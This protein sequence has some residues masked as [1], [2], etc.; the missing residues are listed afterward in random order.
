MTLLYPPR[1]NPV[2][3]LDIGGTKIECAL[4][5]SD[6]TLSRRQ[7]IS[8]K[9]CSS[10]LFGAISELLKSVR[11]D[12]AVEALGVGCGGPM[13]NQGEFVSPL[14]I[15]VWREFS[16]LDSLRKS[17]GLDAFID[18]DAKALAL[19]E[20]RFGGAKGMSNYLSMVV[21]TGVGGGIVLDGR[22]LDG[23]E[24]NAGHIGHVIVLP[25]GRDC[26]CGARGCLEAE[27]SG[28]AIEQMTGAPA[29]AASLEVKQ[30]TGFLVGRAV[31][32]VAAL[33]D[34]ERCFI[35]GSVALGFGKP[36]FDAANDSVR[37]H[38]HISHASTLLIEPSLLTSD[39]PLLGAACV[40]WRALDE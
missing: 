40:A 32:S 3:A 21:S 22:L 28:A 10:N 8:T 12:T 14:N 11:R 23:S 15:P 16:L 27:T 30:R 5:E 33:L 6:G 1:E 13:R 36:F 37:Q 31:S 19:G 17:T 18:N 25:D 35:A 2:L 7:R 34:V 4:V 38:A 9:E 20:G 26:A 29:I 24:G 39:G